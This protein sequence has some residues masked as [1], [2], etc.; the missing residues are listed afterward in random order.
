MASSPRTR[1]D[2]VHSMAVCTTKAA[3]SGSTARSRAVGRRA[4]RTGPRAR[5]ARAARSAHGGAEVRVLEVALPQNALQAGVEG[6]R[7]EQ[8]VDQRAHAGARVAVAPALRREAVDDVVG[9][10]V[11]GAVEQLEQDGALVLEV[12]VER[13]DGDARAPRDGRGRRLVVAARLEARD[14]GLENLLAGAPAAGLLRRAQPRGAGLRGSGGAACPILARAG[15]RRK[16]ELDVRFLL[17]PQGLQITVVFA[18]PRSD[19]R[20]RAP[21][22]TPDHGHGSRP[23]PL[24]LR[25]GSTRS[26]KP[27]SPPS[28]PTT[29]GTTAA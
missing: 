22:E 14:G 29:R 24:P 23:P 27:S 20:P 4:P 16:S 13:A 17:T 8:R 2:A 9:D 3:A 6:P 7:G 11:H 19:A 15:A 12:A 25:T 21:E 28:T 26:S 5:R 1:R 18:D 10:L